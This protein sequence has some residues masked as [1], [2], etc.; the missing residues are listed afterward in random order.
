MLF[1][2]L[3]STSIAWLQW[4]K[5]ENLRTQLDGA[6]VAEE[7]FGEI[8]DQVFL[9][10]Q[11]AELSPST[12]KLE[13]KRDYLRQQVALS[14][15]ELEGRAF[16]RALPVTE[17]VSQSS[18]ALRETD[19]P[20]AALETVFSAIMHGETAKIESGILVTEGAEVQLKEAFES[21]PEA[22]RAAFPTPEALFASV[23]AAM[24]PLDTRIDLELGERLQMSPDYAILSP[25]MSYEFGSWRPKLEFRRIDGR[26]RL[27]VSEE[28]AARY[29]AIVRDWSRG[30]GGE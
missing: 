3:I 16:A 12:V 4:T 9:L 7:R 19:T 18:R 28:V 6:R 8:R 5:Q 15:A 24:V 22:A 23:T 21:I 27:V 11:E 2:A 10:E 1:V 14:Y 30:E 17:R 20:D 26:W 13:Q 29:A 25:L